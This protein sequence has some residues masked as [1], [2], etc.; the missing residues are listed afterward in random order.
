MKMFDGAGHV[1]YTAEEAR[2]TAAILN[3]AGDGHTYR[4]IPLP[5]GMA[6]VAVYDQAGNFVEYW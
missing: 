5:D 3:Q 6:R 4:V 2:A 1:Y